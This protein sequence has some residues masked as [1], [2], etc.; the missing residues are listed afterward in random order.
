MSY[1]SNK[2]NGSY[3][4]GYVPGYLGDFPAHGFSVF[5]V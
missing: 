5:N 2:N 4:Q 3:C 1:K